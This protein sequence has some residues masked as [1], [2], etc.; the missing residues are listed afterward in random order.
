MA[1][2]THTWVGAQPAPS[3]VGTWGWVGTAKFS[4]VDPTKFFY[5]ISGLIL[6]FGVILSIALITLADRKTMGS[7]QRRLGPNKVGYLGI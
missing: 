7:M 5:M 2:P 4:R 6:I 1:P 3:T